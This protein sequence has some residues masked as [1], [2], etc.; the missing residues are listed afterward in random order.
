MT[1]SQADR[2]EPVS[3]VGHTRRTSPDGEG[4]DCERADRFSW[5]S[6]GVIRSGSRIDDVNTL[7]GTSVL[8]P[9]VQPMHPA[10]ASSL[11]RGG[12]RGAARAGPPSSRPFRRAFGCGDCEVGARKGKPRRATGR[13]VRD[14]GGETP[15]LHSGLKPRGRRS[16]DPLCNGEGEGDWPA[17]ARSGGWMEGR[18]L[19]RARHW[20]G[21]VGW[22]PGGW[23]SGA[24]KPDEPQDRWPAATCW[25]AGRWSKPSR[26][27]SNREDGTGCRGW[28]PLP[29]QSL[30]WLG[31]GHRQ[32]MPMERRQA[33]RRGARTCVSRVVRAGP[34]VG[35]LED[36]G[37]HG[38][39]RA[40]A[41]CGGLE[42]PAHTRRRP[43]VA[44]EG[45]RA[46]RP[47]SEEVMRMPWPPTEL[48]DRTWSLSASAG[49]PHLP[50][51][52][53]C[54]PCCDTPA[55]RCPCGAGGRSRLR[56]PR[57]DPMGPAVGIRPW[58]HPASAGAARRW[59]GR[60][61]RPRS[62]TRCRRGGG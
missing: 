21:R 43:G 3:R 20:R 54:F 45:P 30:R 51:P 36:G 49:T 13:T 35:L 14:T 24:R 31:S 58:R 4:L 11:P 42:A 55:L 46:S 6:H 37:R 52:C 19:W 59:P 28:L 60:R 34:W 10:G 18:T 33:A 27:E 22:P 44:R 48:P 57:D 1:L 40:R 62:G 47:W 39:S 12:T 8:G 50:S 23:R 38:E 25:T 17:S 53:R 61:R 56:G 15:D 29:E 5:L 2:C 32:E 16:V 7:P 26:R 41:S 9:R